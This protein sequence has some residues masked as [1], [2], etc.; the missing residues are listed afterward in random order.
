MTW[1]N[2]KFV[3]TKNGPVLLVRAAKKAEKFGTGSSLAG[4]PFTPGSP[5]A[6][7]WPGAPG[8]PCAP[9]GP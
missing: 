1:V 2:A 9:G 6:P 3:S 8:G 7:R 4:I 5:L